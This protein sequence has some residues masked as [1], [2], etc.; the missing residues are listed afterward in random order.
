MKATRLPGFERSSAPDLIR[1]AIGEADVAEH[2]EGAGPRCARRSGSRSVLT[3]SS[4]TKTESDARGAACPSRR[5]WRPT[6]TPGGAASITTSFGALL[7]AAELAGEV[8]DGVHRDARAAARAHRAGP[9]GSP[10]G[11]ASGTRSP[12]GRGSWDRASPSGG[13]PSPILVRAR[14]GQRSAG[15]RAVRVNRPPRRREGAAAARGSGAGEC[16]PRRA[17]SPRRRGGARRPP[18]GCDRAAR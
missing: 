6:R 1:P 10:R 14:K 16:R 2:G 9:G 4:S 15:A 11:V 7:A 3:R 8:A 13:E 5:R 18:R 12:R 17:R